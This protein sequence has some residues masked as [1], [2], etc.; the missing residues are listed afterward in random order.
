[1]MLTVRKNYTLANLT[2][3]QKIKSRKKCLKEAWKQ[4]TVAKIKH[5][6]CIGDEHEKT[7]ID[8]CIY[9]NKLVLL[10]SEDVLS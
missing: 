4:D 5:S 1:M 3:K 2:A 10:I 6:I 7:R 9:D 8:S